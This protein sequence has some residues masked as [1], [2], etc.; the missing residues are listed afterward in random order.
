MDKKKL[1]DFVKKVEDNTNDVLEDSLLDKEA[2]LEDTRCYS[3]KDIV[4][5]SNKDRISKLPW[6]IAIALILTISLA[7]GYMFFRGNPQT[8]FIKTVD[9]FFGFLN[10]NISDETYDISKSNIMVNMDVSGF[11]TN[12]GKI[13]M[14]TTYILDRANGYSRLK[15]LNKENDSSMDIYSDS[16]SIYIKPDV[17]D[18]YIKYDDSGSKNFVKIADV[19]SL[20]NGINQAF[21]KVA[22]DE[23]IDGQKVN[24]DLGNK[25]IKVY[26]SSLVIDDKNYDRV[27]DTF[28]NTLKSN[29]GFVSSLGNITL[30]NSEDVKGSL[31]SFLVKFKDY[32]KS[33]EKTVIKLY[34]DRN[35][36]SFLK[37]ELITKDGTVSF[38]RNDDSFTVSTDSSIVKGDMSIKID[39]G[40]CDIDISFDGIFKLDG[41]VSISSKKI[42]SFGKF[43]MDKIIDEKDLSDEEKINIFSKMFGDKITNNFVKDTDS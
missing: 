28:I 42:S 11:G 2:S 38:I 27:S 9:D 4:K 8:I 13:D 20:F 25:T 15:V 29:E 35:N 21:D 17:Y 36:N 3:Y 32:L 43:K 39:N 34:T 40:K 7:F 41:K 12:L 22:A 5:I 23:K 31:D 14:D 19:K 1:D 18:G 24:Y 33:S 16:K 6:L 30:K 26:Q 37:G 10:S